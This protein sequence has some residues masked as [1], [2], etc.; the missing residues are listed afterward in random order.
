MSEL[1][2]EAYTTYASAA[3]HY[4]FNATGKNPP[5]FDKL[6]PELQA[7][8]EATAAGTVASWVY[9]DINKALRDPIRLAEAGAVLKVSH[10]EGDDP[11]RSIACMIGTFMMS[12]AKSDFATG[13]DAREV[14]PPESEE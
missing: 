12:L 6:P 7:A 8:W 11:L 2:R 4:F 10:D 9:N 5:D 3:A 13:Y 14:Q 1:A